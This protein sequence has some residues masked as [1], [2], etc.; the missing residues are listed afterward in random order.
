M[1][2]KGR[3]VNWWDAFNLAASIGICLS[4]AAAVVTWWISRSRVM[5]A[6]PDVA[7]IAEWAGKDRETSEQGRVFRIQNIGGAG[8]CIQTINVKGCSLSFKPYQ[9]I[10][11][12]PTNVLMPGERLYLYAT[13]V[14]GEASLV[15][16]YITHDNAKIIHYDRFDIGKLVPESYLLCRYVR[17]S[18]R[19][20]FDMRYRC[21]QL[22]TEDGISSRKRTVRVTRRHGADA[23][24]NADLCLTAKGYKSMYIG[25]SGMYDDEAEARQA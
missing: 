9:N 2:E 22:F 14:T 12:E 4:I 8:M 21:G 16:Q 20:R 15:V 19:Q 6:Y 7:N 25:F 23:I 5:D 17:P 1:T 24:E 13:E 18:M 10:G 11:S 3:I